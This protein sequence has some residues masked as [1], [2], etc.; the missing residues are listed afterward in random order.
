MSAEGTKQLS[1][2]PA[3]GVVANSDIFYS[4]NVNTTVEQATTALQ[5]QNYVLAPVSNSTLTDAGTLSGVETLP[6]GRGGLL[7]TTIQKI[8]N[9]VM[10]GL[11]PQ[12]Q[13]IPVTTAGQSTY[14]T[15]GYT[16]GIVNVFIAGIR[17][18]PSRY[19]ALDG[20]NIIITDPTV[21]ARLVVGMTI[22]IEAAVTINTS[23]AATVA[24]VNALY[25]A[26]QPVANP[27]T[28]TELVSISQM[29]SLFHSTLT[30]TASWSLQAYKGYLLP[31]S[32]ANATQRTVSA[33]LSDFPTVRS[34]GMLADGVTEESASLIT[35]TTNYSTIQIP[36][37]QSIYIATNVTI[38]ANTTIVGPGTIKLGP[39]GTLTLG[40]GS[41]LSGVTIDGS[42]QTNNGTGV[43]ARTGSV[44]VRLLFCKL[45]N[46]WG[47][48]FVA[49]TGCTKILLYETFMSNI[50]GPGIAITSQG[51]GVYSIGS[52]ID[53][54]GGFFEK[55]YGQAAIFI[56]GTTRANIEGAR[57][58]DTAYR[59]I[60]T[61]STCTAVS[62]TECNIMRTGSMNAGP[63]G[64]GCNGMYLL[65]ASVVSDIVASNNWIENVGENCIEGFATIV[66]NTCINSNYNGLTTPSIEGIYPYGGSIVDN[67]RIHNAKGAGIN[68]YQT[69]NLTNL[70]ITRNRIFNPGSTGI[71]VNLNGSGLVAT[72]VIVDGNEI[73]DYN[74]ANSG[75]YGVYLASNGGSSF[76]S[77]FCSNNKLIGGVR[78]LN[79]ISA[80]ILESHN[81]FDKYHTLTLQD[82]PIRLT[83]AASN[84]TG[85]YRRHAYTY[86]I[87]FNGTAFTLDNLGN[88]LTAI[89]HDNNSI[90]LY[91]VP[92]TATGPLTSA[93]LTAYQVAQVTA[94]GFKVNGQAWNDTRLFQIGAYYLWIDSFGRLR[95]KGS[96]P[97]SDTD[98]RS[99]GL[100]YIGS[101]VGDNSTVPGSATVK[102]IVYNTPL[103]VNRSVN[104]PTSG[105][106]DGDRMRVTRMAAATGGSTLTITTTPNKVLAA[107]QWADC[108]WWATN[109]IWIVTGSG[110]V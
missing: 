2:F 62:I 41:V 86:G 84:A 39:G 107:G 69:S 44:D 55:T 65:G 27:L 66:N 70:S 91:N 101:D 78:T 24:S 109:S 40:S 23:N 17:L 93:Q 108:E 61:Y 79:T 75:L 50:G 60:Q 83:S 48:G 106:N 13:S 26:N 28:G 1:D 45:I 82:G 67:N 80:G 5:I 7:Q 10:S 20:I 33:A 71:S 54:V 14:V 31:N 99:L 94:T 56:N 72:G 46:I 89:V 29:G 74:A 52:E 4:A 43:L 37:G 12:Q 8:A 98:G 30:N 85:G 59:G 42:N 15:S 76:T 110:S 63:S 57:I 105:N 104:L 90:G 18:S 97:T 35:A 103:T 77:S 87:D 81:S 47:D 102:T 68:L 51:C 22:D 53:V 49:Q 11:S 19:Q 36:A 21:L 6:V 3:T 38:P 92:P 73:Y 95:F 25:P 58:R 34:A 96:A 16:P 100:G 9:F 88:A 64:V 32:I